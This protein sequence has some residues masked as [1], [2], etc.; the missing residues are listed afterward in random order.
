[1]GWIDR[2]R[3]AARREDREVGLHPFGAAGREDRDRVVLL[4]AKREQAGGELA[5]DLAGLPP[6]PGAPDAA[7]LRL[8][9]RAIA[10]ALHP[11]PEH[12][13]QRHVGHGLLLTPGCGA[14]CAG[15]CRSGSWA[16][17]RRNGSASGT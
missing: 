5:H 1:V 9:G 10:V 15:S 4:A 13:R 6:G 8:L 16:A 2:N 11:V 14:L 17:S 3:A 12:G 7:F